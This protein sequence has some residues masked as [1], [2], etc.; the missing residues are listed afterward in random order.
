MRA[1]I[2]P[3]LFAT[4]LGAAGSI[5]PVG[6]APAA[7]PAADA[8]KILQSRLAE[9][10]TGADAALLSLEALHL[11][12]EER[13]HRPAWSADGRP[14]PQVGQLVDALRSASHEGLRPADY[15][16]ET[17]EALRRQLKE[18]SRA[19]GETTADIVD[20]DL[21]LSDAFFLYAGHLTSGRVNPGSIE[22]EWNIPGR[23]R[24]L[25]LLLA[26]ALERGHLADT[27]SRLPPA[28]D[29]YRRL[30]AALA[31]QRAVAAA[32][33]WPLV[34]W[35]PALRAGDRGPRVAALRR[36]L[37]ATGELAAGEEA[38]ELF[39]APLGEALR[40]FQARHG[41]ETDAVAGRRTI[42]ALN[43]SSVQRARQIEAN[44]ERLRWL[45]RDLGP[46]HLVVNVPDFRL[47]L[48]EDGAPALTMRVIAGRQSRRTPFFTGEITSIVVNPPWTVPETIALEDK[49]PLILD[50]RDFFASE[51]FK[52]FRR[53]GKSWREIDPADVD[54]A[55]LPP[56]RF[57]Y[58]LRQ[59]PGP[60]NALGRLKFQVPNRHDIYLHDTPSRG[61]FARDG[62]AYSSG[63]I[64]VERAVDLAAR[65]LAPD[66]A[67]SREKI[68]AAIAAGE[69]VTVPLR[70]PM[71]VYLLYATAWVD[72]DGSL[73][74]RE[75]IYGRDAALLEALVLPPAAEGSG[76]KPRAE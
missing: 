63:C 17:I 19:A 65:L 6:Q 16:L 40:R 60:R 7:N 13:G 33:G 54:W 34:P 70:R 64:R 22:P 57:P 14:S 53:V 56:E 18:P 36:R 72:P 11:F 3:L 35:G 71:P 46:R 55:R 29:G 73:Q 43:A 15:R 75:D 67:W 10:R 23:G 8:A 61:L 59:E 66:P 74:F 44:L 21:I 52:L 25:T 28:D 49:L 48:T 41:L 37:A 5:A 39:D 68:E 27:I 30:R 4:L 12:Y 1:T 62:R 47:T 20:L 9:G 76:R 58:R 42:A 45:P 26:A 69:T 24:A 51:G 31:A 50:D 32:G 2:R 38:G